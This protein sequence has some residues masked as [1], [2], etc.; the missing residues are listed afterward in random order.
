MLITTQNIH[1]SGAQIIDCQM[2]FK[3]NSSLSKQFLRKTC[4]E[5]SPK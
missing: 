5:R 3:N 1:S 2:R 4:Y